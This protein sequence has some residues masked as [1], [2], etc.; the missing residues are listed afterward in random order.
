MNDWPLGAQKY[1]VFSAFALGVALIAAP[2]SAQAPVPMPEATTTEAPPE[3]PIVQAIFSV[4]ALIVAGQ[5]QQAL[6]EVER[7]LQRSPEDDDWRVQHAR[8]LYWLG[9]HEEAEAE[10]RLLHQRRPTDIELTDLLAQILLAR[11]NLRASV[12]LYQALQTAGD[13][14]PEVSQ[15]IVDLLLELEDAAGVERALEIGGNLD[16]EQRLKYEKLRH[17]WLSNLILSSN[18]HEAHLWPRVEADLGKRLSKSATILVGAFYERRYT[19]TKTLQ[20]FAPKVEGYFKIGHLDLMG[21]LNISPSL[22]FLPLVDARADAMYGINNTVSAGIY[23]RGAR[24]ASANAASTTSLTF[25]PNA[26]FFRGRWIIQPGY[27]AIVNLPGSLLN[28]LFFKFRFQY[29]AHTTF[30][31]WTFIGQ[32]PTAVERFGTA[33]LAQSAGVSGLLGVDHWLTPRYGVRFSISRVQPFSDNTAP[34]TEVTLGL[35]G[36]F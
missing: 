30:L 2:S 24:Y 13:M 29:T 22:S 20:A 27:M 11:G 6:L 10:T 34:F 33:D 4:R 14:R 35:R 5:F 21:H 26:Q 15:R 32:D 1:F 3:A 31:L 12:E 9:R 19:D 18:L 8:L 16:E 17:P 7:I 25:A 28:S 36:R 23:L